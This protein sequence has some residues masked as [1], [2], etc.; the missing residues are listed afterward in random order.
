MRELAVLVSLCLMLT[1]CGFIAARNE[2]DCPVGTLDVD[3]RGEEL[4]NFVALQNEV[5]AVLA[6][7][8][9]PTTMREIGERVGWSME[10]DRMIPLE[11]TSTP[12]SVRAAA[13][14]DDPALCIEG[15]PSRDPFAHKV[16]Y[17]NSLFLSGG[18]PVERVEWFRPN[19]LIRYGARGYLEPDTELIIVGSQLVPVE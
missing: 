17:P 3:P 2:P 18:Q 16:S 11:H 5:R 19:P 10:W 8:Q 12:A 6:N 14:L 7:G 1:S 4:G 9:A 13:G 15:I